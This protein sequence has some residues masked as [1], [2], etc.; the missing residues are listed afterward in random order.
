MKKRLFALALVLLIACSLITPAAAFVDHNYLYTAVDD[1]DN[2]RL[3]DAGETTLPTLS[4]T[5][6]FDLRVDIVSTTEGDTIE[7]YAELFYTQYEYG[8]GDNKDGSLLMILLDDNGDSV[9]FND[10]YIY[11]EGLGRDISA[12]PDSESFYVMLD[13]VLT[14]ENIPY[15]EAGEICANAVD[16]Y[17]GLMAS[18]IMTV[19]PDRAGVAAA[20]EMPEMPEA[21]PQPEDEVILLEGGPERFIQDNA[22]LISVLKT[23]TMENR[24]VE[25]ANA[26]GCGVYV[27]TVDTMNGA[28]VREFAKDYYT[29]HGLGVDEFSN[30]ILFLVAMDTREYVTITYGRDPEALTDYGIGILAFTD[31]GIEVLEEEVVSFLGDGDYDEAFETYL[32]ICEEYLSYYTENGEGMVPES[33]SER[34]LKVAAVIFIPLIIALIVCLVFLSQM[35]TAKIAK[36]AGN[37]VDDLTVTARHDQYTHTTRERREISK[38]DDSDGSGHTV[39]SDG[40]GGSKGGKF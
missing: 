30:G 28:E 32:D 1:I 39:D 3:L 31:K 7:E 18:M 37:Y 24:A 25:M 23:A 12:L 8:Y 27:L 40:F 10:Y 38:D 29:Q 5:Y 2:Q 21:A 26:Y 4:E 13:M 33:S 17:T 14:G 6:Q 19:A 9:S 36:E 35:K 15:E 22:Q 11:T 20:P 16:T 34:L